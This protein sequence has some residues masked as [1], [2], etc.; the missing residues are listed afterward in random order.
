[1]PEIVINVDREVTDQ[2]QRELDRA[3]Q[4]GPPWS[5]SS[6]F[7]HRLLQQLRDG[8]RYYHF[9]YNE[10]VKATIADLHGQ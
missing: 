9:D 3:I 8:K 2:L 4:K 7:L 5:L 1:M 6:R 10:G